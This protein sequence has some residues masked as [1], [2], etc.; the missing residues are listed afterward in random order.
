MVFFLLLLTGCSTEDT[1]DIEYPKNVTVNEFTVSWDAVSVDDVTY[2]LYVE[3]MV[4]HINSIHENIT[5][6]S[7]LLD[8]LEENT[9]YEVRVQAINVDG[10]SIK[11]NAVIIDTFVDLGTISVM[12]NYLSD[13]S[14]S[15]L[16]I[17]A[18]EIYCVRFAKTTNEKLPH[19][20]FSLQNGVFTINHD[21]I[22]TDT[23]TKFFLYTNNGLIELK[24][25][26]TEN[27]TPT[28]MSENSVDFMNEDL[29]F[30]FDFAGGEFVEINGSDI[31]TDDYELINNVLIIDQA[32]I[33]NLF[34]EDLD[35]NK[36]ILSYQLRTDD[37]IKIGYL[38]ISRDP[39]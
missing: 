1:G 39:E 22:H 16:G 31:T 11:T 5:D 34:N 14:L 6:T 32:F 29:Y 8:E 37:D 24:V 33:S 12:Y 13:V 18:T 19:E 9:T 17:D 38:F 36:V 28:I 30:E 25:N 27:E 21:S 35:R 10:S 2:T 4:H 3:D 26:K 23:L 20:A 7:Y 15:V